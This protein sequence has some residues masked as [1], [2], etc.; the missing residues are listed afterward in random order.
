M[1]RL[2][3]AR[4]CSN[5]VEAFAQAEARIDPLDHR[6]R[7]LATIGDEFGRYDI[8]FDRIEESMPIFGF[9]VAEDPGVHIRAIIQIIAFWT[10]S[11]AVPQLS[12]GRRELHKISGDGSQRR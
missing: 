9:D 4:P 10:P 7:N 8:G 6:R 5:S 12:G 1:D 3:P 11:C 2:S